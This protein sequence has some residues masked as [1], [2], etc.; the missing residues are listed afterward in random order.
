MILCI[1]RCP[2][3]FSAFYTSFVAFGVSFFL[4]ISDLT[5]MAFAGDAL[6]MLEERGIVIRFVIGRRLTCFKP[7]ALFLWFL[8]LTQT[9]KVLLL[10]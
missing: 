7:L 1:K 3:I 6:K 2:S 5:L 10:T 8:L 4:S 9:S